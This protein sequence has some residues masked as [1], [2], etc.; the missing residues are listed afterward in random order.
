VIATV[1]ATSYSDGSLIADSSYYR[2]GRS[3]GP[4]TSR[5]CRRRA[6]SATADGHEQRLHRRHLPGSGVQ[7]GVWDG[8]YPA[9]SCS[10]RSS[11]G[12]PRPQNGTFSW[13]ALDAD[14]ARAR[15]SG[16][17]LIVRISCVSTPPAGCSARRRAVAA[18]S[19]ST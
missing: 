6:P 15:T 17:R 10:R 1:T 7:H 2:C 14:L 3:T 12:R 18:M 11:L 19:R 5:R 13:A 9:S 8:N 4:A 16:N